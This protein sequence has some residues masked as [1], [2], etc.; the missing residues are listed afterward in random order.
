MRL[1]APLACLFLSLP[2]LTAQT[3]AAWA[4]DADTGKT[5]TAVGEVKFGQ[6]GPRRPDYPR[7]DTKNTAVRFEG[8]G[9]RLEVA[10]V[11][12]K[13]VFDFA[14]GDTVTLEAW[15][16]PD[17]ISKGENVYL[18]GKGRTDPKAGNPN[19]Q[20][21]ALRLREMYGTACLSFLFASQEPGSSQWHRWTTISGLPNDGRWHHV[22]VRYQFG[23][24]ESIT[25]TIDGQPRKGAWDMDGPTTR[26][27]VV[28]DAPVWIGSSMGGSAGS[29]Y[30]GLISSIR[31]HRR[32]LSDQELADAFVTTLPPIPEKPVAAAGPSP[33]AG[34]DVNTDTSK[35]S[36]PVLPL[37]KSAPKVDWS[38]VPSDRVLVEICD[39]WHP[40]KNMWPTE[41]LKLTE[42]HETP[43][44]ALARLPEKYVD[45]GVRGERGNPYFLR[46]LAKVKL[47]AG[48]HRLL[49]R[50]RGASA[51]FID[52][53]LQVVTPF[54]PAGSDNKPVKV[55][56]AKF[57]DLGP[58]FRFITPGNQE[59]WCEFT[60]TEGEHQIVLESVIGYIAGTKGQRRRP[61][62][63]E[64]VAAISLSGRTDWQILSPSAAPIPYDDAG[65][66]AY[67]SREEKRLAAIDSAK[68]AELRS[69]NAE[70]WEKRRTAARA[71]LDS[72]PAP[73]IPQVDAAFP[74]RNPID[75]FVAEK[76]VAYRKQAT[77]A[78]ANGVEFYA[79]IQ[80][81][82]EA[83][84]L[85]CHQGGKA[86]GGL[87][88]DTRAGAIKGGKSD[89][90]SI[91]PGRPDKSPLLARILSRDPDEMM[92]P[93]GHRLSKSDTDLITTWIREGA[94]WPEFRPVSTE[95]TP[96]TDDLAFLRRVTLD[97]V[98]VVPTEAEISAFLADTAPDKRVKAID[99]LLA[100]P[101][102]A[103]NWVGYWQD[104]LAENPNILNP[105]L[106]NSGPFRWWIHESLLDNK[107]LDLMVTEL[108]R[109][110]GSKR[111]GG[112]AGFGVASQNDVPMAAKATIV[113]TAFLGVET[114][115]AR[116]H[117]APAHTAK[118]EQVFALAAL[119]ETKPVKVP[120]TSSVSMEKL[121]EG[122]R[123]PL[124]E[125]TLAPGTAVE[126][127]WPFPEFSTES[128]ADELA[129]D[130]N[131][132]RDRLATLITAPQNERFPQVMANRLWARLMGRGIVDQPWDWERSRNTHPELLSWLG[133]ELVRSG[134][135][136]RHV[137][138]LI[139]NSHAYQ[140]AT[141]PAQK[142]P[143]PL[144]AAPAPRR[145]TAEQIVD[146][147]F[148]ATGKPFRTEEASLDIDN[149]REQ[150]NSCN[151]GQPRR[152]WMLT[153]TSNERDRPA[154][155]LPRIQAVCDALAAFGWRASRPDP[156]TDREAAANSLQPAILSNG[157]MGTWL[158]RLSDDH[159]VTALALEAKSP[160]EFVD[161]LFLR[162]LTRHPTASEKTRFTRMLGEGFATRADVPAWT[163]PPR[164]ARPAYYVSWSN[165]LD[166]DATTVRMEQEKEARRGDVPTPRLRAD[167]R[168]RAEDAVWALVNSPE[169]LFTP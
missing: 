21:W 122:G 80:P 107:P 105:T 71:W 47:P 95:L 93:K 4:F 55:Q 16:K 90:P 169:F 153:S 117:D 139:M 158:T 155:A 147:A 39:D 9:S 114:K 62:L 87:H 116:C 18:I 103:D 57:L 121:R 12:E 3:P 104:V 61:E 30:R 112:P 1:F 58:G 160:E 120:A 162:V 142:L 97:T 141:N 133:R 84:C 72:H 149:N 92:P 132:P 35:P 75:A 25:A 41:Q 59:A 79:K 101:R 146:S 5:L 45:T 40:E 119:L 46:A 166:N 123:K 65:W 115:C 38:A 60:C 143:N 28:D 81:I 130:P 88:L 113:T 66:E 131:D 127:H 150:E 138:R 33:N 83:S 148:A 69:A 128:V 48:K 8:K 36:K 54:A 154:L 140:R 168:L 6:P 134:Y 26:G 99:R 29:S 56:Q 76:I 108:L 20:N 64:T 77:A 23:K 10:D 137:L 157:T 32:G 125:V 7:F 70:Y 111:Y 49:L 109:L 63:G 98:G 44:L 42:R 34:N 164:P 17:A 100:D 110:R 89:G 14:N 156:L 2:G 82:L 31:L 165:H 151:L 24:P 136:T 129:Q 94:V 78:P 135:D 124:I 144:Y 22:A 152:A 52:G 91:E 50:G 145:L 37:V 11:G 73:A 53:K 74:V 13:S 159:G 161:R 102:Y 163:P 106:N 51:L 43:A 27:P 167:W 67:V 19:N 68:R 86:K 126:P 15:V 96:L 85:E 118:Q